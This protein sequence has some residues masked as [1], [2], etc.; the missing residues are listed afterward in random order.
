MGKELNEDL[1]YQSE[2]NSAVFHF[3][4]LLRECRKLPKDHR[5]SLVQNPPIY[6]ENLTGAFEQTCDPQLSSS[7][8]EEHEER[9]EKY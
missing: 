1:K 9:A 2:Q 8:R 6:R 5:Q 3:L 4:F 7:R